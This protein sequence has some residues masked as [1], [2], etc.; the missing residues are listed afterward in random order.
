MRSLSTVPYLNFIFHNLIVLLLLCIRIESLPG[1]FAFEEEVEEDVAER[2]EV[3]SS[4]LFNAQMIG[5]TRVTGCTS[6]MAIL[7]VRDVMVC[8]GVEITLG[9]TVVDDVDE[10]GRSFSHTN[11]KVVRFDITMNE[12][13]VMDVLHTSDHLDCQHVD[14]LLGEFSVAKV[15]QILQTWTQQIHHHYILHRVG[16]VHVHVGDTVASF[17]YSVQLGLRLKL[18]GLGLCIFDLDGYLHVY[19]RKRIGKEHGGGDILLRVSIPMWI[20]PKAPLPILLRI[21]YCFMPLI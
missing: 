7:T 17:K 15:E 11:D 19:E 6:E 16:F 2:F 9:E 20:S 14:S 1:Q 12:V 10:V 4:T 13:T 21:S 8:V 3:I 5:E 18:R